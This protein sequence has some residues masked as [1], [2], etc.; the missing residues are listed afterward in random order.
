MWEMGLAKYTPMQVAQANNDLGIRNT[1]GHDWT[2]AN[3]RDFYKNPACRGATV[4]GRVQESELHPKRRAIG[5]MRNAHQAM[6]TPEKWDRVNGYIAERHNAPAGPRSHSSL[7]LLSGR[8]FCGHCA[9]PMH[10]ITNNDGTKSLICSKKK[11]QGKAACPEAENVRLKD[12][13]SEVVTALLERILTKESLDQQVVAVAQENE[14][15]LLEQQT[16]REHIQKAQS[17][18]RRQIKNLVTAIE[19][20]DIHTD[21]NPDPELYTRLNQ[22]RSE[23]Q[24]LES[25]IEELD[26]ITGDHLMFLNDPDLIVRNALDLRTYLESGDEQTAG[27][28][29]QS[30]VNNVVIHNKSTAPSTTASRFRAMAPTHPRHKRSGSHGAATTKYVLWDGHTGMIARHIRK[31]PVR[32]TLM[33]FTQSAMPLPC[34]GPMGPEFPALLTS[35]LIRPNRSTT[36]WANRSV[37]FWLVT[38]VRTAIA[39]VP[40]SETALTASC[41]SDSLRA[42]S[43]SLAPSRA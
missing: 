26:A 12:V 4:R 24:S 41:S 23:L 25:K 6:V 10:V 19:D 15:F 29:V 32:L 2:D 27:V 42:A 30:F 34:N 18:A 9:S 3:V 36:L 8:I 39:S 31:V 20:M 16:N 28:F 21:R 7:N 17:R 35:T 5:S 43:A 33:V 11:H 13:L 40:S 38:S 1:E 22:R 37:S 14:S